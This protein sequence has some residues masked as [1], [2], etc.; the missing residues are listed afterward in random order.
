V[1]PDAAATLLIAADDNTDRLRSEASRALHVVVHSRMQHDP[2]T[3]AYVQWRTGQG[4]SRRE[5]M[6]CLKRYVARELF[7]LLPR[8]PVDKT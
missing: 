2:R 5:I 7:H 4:L 8:P 3:C 6:R 1:G